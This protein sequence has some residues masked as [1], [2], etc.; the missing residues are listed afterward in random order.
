MEWCQRWSHGALDELALE[1]DQKWSRALDELETELK[2]CLVCYGAPLVLGQVHK[3]GQDDVLEQAHKPGQPL[4]QQV[5]LD[6]AQG[7]LDALDVQ[8]VVEE[9][10]VSKALGHYDLYA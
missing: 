10:H 5:Q 7:G 3:L 9:F 6:E 8:D 1:W 4:G 2:R